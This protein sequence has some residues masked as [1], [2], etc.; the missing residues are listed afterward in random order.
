MASPAIATSREPTAR[1]PQVV[2]G[3]SFVGGRFPG[4]ADRQPAWVAPD[5][6]SEGPCG[7][8]V[9]AAGGDAVAE[10][11]FARGPHVADPGE[12]DVLTDDRFQVTPGHL[13]PVGTVLSQNGIGWCTT[14]RPVPVSYTTRAGDLGSAHSNHAPRLTCDLS[15]ASHA[16]PSE[17]YEASGRGVQGRGTRSPVPRLVRLTICCCFMAVH[18]RGWL[19]RGHAGCAAS[20]MR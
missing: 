6:V 19:S 4:V 5:V 9:P 12:V 20:L 10:L 16:P 14:S 15:P 3:A 2:A 13:G 7:R 18:P 17:P 11:A 8:W 1:K